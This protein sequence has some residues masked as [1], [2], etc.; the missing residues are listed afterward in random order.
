ML[1][2]GATARS[3]GLSSGSETSRDGWKLL[4]PG[5]CNDGVVAFAVGADARGEEECSVAAECKSARKRHD[6][7]RQNALSCVIQRSGEG[8]DRARAAKPM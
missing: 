2:L 4:T 7:W 5:K 3:S 1:P 6:P 8:H